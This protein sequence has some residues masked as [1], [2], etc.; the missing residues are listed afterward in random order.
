MDNSIY[1]LYILPAFMTIYGVFLV[2]DHKNGRRRFYSYRSIVI[3]NDDERR[4]SDELYSISMF[5]VGAIETLVLI[6]LSCTLF[7]GEFDSQFIE[8]VIFIF[9]LALFFLVYILPS[10]VVVLERRKG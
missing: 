7:D 8:F 6:I 5:F 3:R 4:R 1:A 2:L 9:E 10:A